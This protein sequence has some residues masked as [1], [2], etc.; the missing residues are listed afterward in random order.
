MVAANRARRRMFG[1]NLDGFF[2]LLDLHPGT[3]SPDE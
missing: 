2:Q 1:V 3:R